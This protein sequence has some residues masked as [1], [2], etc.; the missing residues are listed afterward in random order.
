MIAHIN[1]QII[2][3]DGKPAFAVI[4]WNEYQKLLHNR[5]E[6]DESDVWFPNEVVKA[7][8][9]GESLIKAWREYLKLTQAEL[10]S[11]AGMKQSALARLE[12][13]ITNPRKSTLMKLSE[14]MGITVDQLID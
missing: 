2:K 13:N 12:S 10:A 1:P 6:S 3:Q 11:K 5:I 14:A 9:R 7:N 8:V 4:P